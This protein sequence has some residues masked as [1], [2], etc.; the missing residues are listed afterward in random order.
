MA[1]VVGIR[2]E[3]RILVKENRTLRNANAAF[4]TKNRKLQEAN[5][6]YDR[7]QTKLFKIREVLNGG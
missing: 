3:K 7:A 5:E 2:A 6:Q 4:K 1:R